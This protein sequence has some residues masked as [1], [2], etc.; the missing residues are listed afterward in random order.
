MP[1]TIAIRP[2][3]NPNNQRVRFYASV[4]GGVEFYVG[5]G[6]AYGNN[7]G[8]MNLSRTDPYLYDPRDYLQFGFW[9]EYI[10]VTAHCESDRLFTCLNS[11][12]RARFTFGFLQYA[13]HV[14]DNGGLGGDFV[15]WFRE[16]LQFAEGQD[17]F[18]DLTV[19][20]DRIHRKRG[21]QFTQ[22]EDAASTQRLMDYLN[23]DLAAVETTEV[24]N[25]AR[26]VHWTVNH[27]DVRRLQVEHGVALFKSVLKAAA[28]SLQLDGRPDFI[29][30]AVTDIRH[31]GRGTNAQIR[32]ALA[33][34]SQ[35]A[36]LEGL[37]RIGFHDY[38]QRCND[39]RDVVA[40]KRNSGIF[41]TH[42]YRAD[43]GEFVP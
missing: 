32:Q 3:P 5:S 12:D 41:G 8:L 2:T 4:N 30:A 26:L 29:C 17:Y 18:P 14:P 20:N 10:D 28:N 42:T 37:L 38:Q 16:I 40:R 36:Q 35:D 21:Q 9:A 33:A 15:K 19:V 22:L 23:P 7:F 6:V 34:A 24:E 27:S 43:V 13:A 25:A 1:Y 39:L 11:Y 31:Q